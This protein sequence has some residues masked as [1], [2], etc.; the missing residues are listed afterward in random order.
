MAVRLGQWREVIAR[1]GTGVEQEVDDRDVRLEVAPQLRIGWIAFV[2]HPRDVDPMRLEHG[3]I[4]I[5]LGG[6]SHQYRD[7]RRR[8]RQSAMMRSMRSMAI[9]AC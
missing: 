6:R 3:H 4:E 8:P 2:A 1:A 9:K 7:L 5:R